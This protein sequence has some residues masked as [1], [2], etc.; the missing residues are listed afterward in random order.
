VLVVLGT[1]R[2]PLSYD[3]SS[4]G[5]YLRIEALHCPKIRGAAAT[6]AYPCSGITSNVTVEARIAPTLI[7]IALD[8]YP[9]RSLFQ[10]N[11]GGWDLPRGSRFPTPR[12]A[13]RHSSYVT[14]PLLFEIAQ[15]KNRATKP[16]FNALQTSQLTSI[17]WSY[18][19]ALAIDESAESLRVLHCAGKEHI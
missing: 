4:D 6:L 19:H 12:I 3:S 9:P 16:T 7:P 15:E 10:F 18:C 14:T 8:V 11:M 2:I 5:L 13:V 17:G 1:A